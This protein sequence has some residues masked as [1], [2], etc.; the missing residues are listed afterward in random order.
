MQWPPLKPFQKEALNHLEKP[1]HLI[2]VSPTGS[3]KSRI[4]EVFA[5]E[6]ARKTLIVT[7]L[8]ALAR[9]QAEKLKAFGLT[10][11]L[12]AGDPIAK[13]IASESLAKSDVWIASPEQLSRSFYR[14]L[15][16]EWHPDFL[17]VDECHC[18]W[19]WGV[20]FRP[21]FLDLP[22]LARA[23]DRSLWLT[24]TLPLEARLDLRERLPKPLTEMG[25]FSLPENMSLE[26]RKTPWTERAEFLIEWISQRD[27][28][29]G[30]VFVSSRQS[31]VRI[32]R[33]LEATGKRATS[34]HA[35]LSSEERRIVEKKS[36]IARSTFWFPP[37]RLGWGWIILI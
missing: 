22:D 28:R 8:I 19:D 15:F 36:L 31:T 27:G 11:F 7:P 23:V 37:P 34:Y 20:D 35:G 17:V 33:L 30:V 1:G 24:A 9:Q 21:A 12:S 6:K 25:S 3:G 10:P 14:S 2:C 5:R 26:I 18:L 32:S 13:K 16:R 4:Y 29:S